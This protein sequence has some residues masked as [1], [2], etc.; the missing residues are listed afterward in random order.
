M[1]SFSKLTPTSFLDE[2]QK[3]LGEGAGYVSNNE[4]FYFVNVR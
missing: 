1:N 4:S 2:K 3:I